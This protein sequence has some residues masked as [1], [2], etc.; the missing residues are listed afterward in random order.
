RGATAVVGGR[1]VDAP[2]RPAAV[3]DATGAGDCFAAGYLW[4]WLAGA[5]PDA[6]LAYGNL[7]G[8]AAAGSLGGYAGAPTADELR[9]AAGQTVPLD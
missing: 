9:A 2:A 5:G 3:V 1:R 7:C 4:G 8:A 6:C